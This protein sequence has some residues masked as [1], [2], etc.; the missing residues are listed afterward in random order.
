MQKITWKRTLKWLLY[1]SYIAFFIIVLDSDLH[2]IV[3]TLLILS[4][5]GVQLWFGREHLKSA[6]LYGAYKRKGLKDDWKEA[7]RLVKK[8]ERKWK[9]KKKDH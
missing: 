3:K 7:G 5:F 4:F 8:E 9:Q 6:F 1:T 2:G